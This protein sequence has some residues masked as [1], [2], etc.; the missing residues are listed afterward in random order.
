MLEKFA[1]Q[2]MGK[3]VFITFEQNGVRKMGQTDRAGLA[4]IS[5]RIEAAKDSPFS[6]VN[7]KPVGNVRS[8]RN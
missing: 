5:E 7:G 6:N 3:A 8:L 4:V 1:V 2:I